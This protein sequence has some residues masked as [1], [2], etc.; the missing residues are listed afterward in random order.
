MTSTDDT[1]TLPALGMTL[2]CAD[3]VGQ[4]RFWSLALGYVEAPPPAG[5]DTW[6]AFLV[7]HDVP[8]E[9]W[10]DGAVI[11]DPDGVRPGLSLLKVPEPKRAKNRLHLDLK[12][13]GGRHVDADE[14]TRRIDAKVDEL[15]AAGATVFER[16]S[17]AGTL[18]HVS[19]LDPEDNEFCVV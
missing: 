2:D 3:P 17:T 8:R 13:S 1:A 6:E 7:D 9:E 4:A 10:D 12:V 16:Y 14:R 11:T 15:L 19:M 18:D 5:W